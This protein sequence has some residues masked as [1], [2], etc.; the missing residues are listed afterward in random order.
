MISTQS[1][2]GLEASQE[3]EVTESESGARPE[4]PESCQ[5]TEMVMPIVPGILEGVPVDVALCN[6][7]I[8]QVLS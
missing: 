1:P 7:L 6:Q 8:I 4:V 5:V 2:E 3:T